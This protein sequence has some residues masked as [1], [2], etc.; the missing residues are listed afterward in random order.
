M[1]TLFFPFSYFQLLHIFLI[2]VY[3]L[4]AP[5]N[6]ISVN[7]VDDLH[8][9]TEAF[10]FFSFNNYYIWLYSY[11]LNFY[12]LFISFC[13]FFLFL[14]LS[15]PCFGFFF[16]FIFSWFY[17]VFNFFY[18]LKVVRSINNMLVLIQEVLICIINFSKSN[19][20]QYFKH[21]ST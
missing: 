19:I 3:L 11:H 1:F 6:W 15:L 8:L 10:Q 20:N 16:P 18:N 14:F 4:Q 5:Y 7:L 13:N 2:L 12:F 9:F 17:F 21:P